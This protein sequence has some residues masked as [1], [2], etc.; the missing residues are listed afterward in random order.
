MSKLSKSYASPGS[1]PL[2]EDVPLPLF[3][4]DFEDEG[5]IKCSSSI[6]DTIN[7][8]AT[9]DSYGTLNVFRARC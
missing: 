6:I 2:P 9:L 5:P 3:D 4:E 7:D 1:S 8:T